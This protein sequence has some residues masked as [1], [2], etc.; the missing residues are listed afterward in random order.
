MEEEG[1]DMWAPLAVTSREIEVGV[2]LTFH[3]PLCSEQARIHVG[4]LIWRATSVK[5]AKYY[6]S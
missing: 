5:M 6:V 3:V 4:T 1:D 2:K